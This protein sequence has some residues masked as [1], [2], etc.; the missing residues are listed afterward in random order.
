MLRDVAVFLATKAPGRVLIV[1]HLDPIPF[2]AKL[3]A[4]RQQLDLN[5]RLGLQDSICSIRCLGAK[6]AAHDFLLALEGGFVILFNKEF[7]LSVHLL[8]QVFVRQGGLH[9]HN[10]NLRNL[11]LNLFESIFLPLKLLDPH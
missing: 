5:I 9:S 4:F 3:V 6:P 7:I 2:Q 10:H 11:A 8:D 1:R